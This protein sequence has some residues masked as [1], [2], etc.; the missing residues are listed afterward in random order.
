MLPCTFSQLQQCLHVE[1]WDY[2]KRSCS[3]ERNSFSDDRHTRRFCIE[4]IENRN[5]LCKYRRFNK[6]YQL[7]GLHRYKS[8]KNVLYEM[9]LSAMASLKL[10]H[11]KT[12]WLHVKVIRSFCLSYTQ[13]HPKPGK[14]E[15]HLRWHSEQFLM[16]S[17]AEAHESNFLFLFPDVLSKILEM[18]PLKLRLSEPAQNKAS[19]LQSW[20]FWISAHWK[21]PLFQLVLIWL[22][23]N[24]S[25][26]C[27][28]ISMTFMILHTKRVSLCVVA[29]NTIGNASTKKK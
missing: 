8:S 11:W 25:L 16:E 28:I 13:S 19:H 12:C 27:I 22:R 17:T 9:W 5:L 29:E 2:F 6:A 15:K 10:I 26:D 14:H 21:Q 7:C 20:P 3:C 24:K 23:R 1:R 4:G 18:S